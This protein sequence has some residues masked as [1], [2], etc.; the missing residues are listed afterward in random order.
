M[1]QWAYLDQFIFQP[2][3][4]SLGRNVVG[5]VS[6]NLNG[7]GW[8]RWRGVSRL[9]WAW[10]NFDVNAT[11]H[12]IGGFREIVHRPGVSEAFPNAVHE[13]WTN[14]TNF[15]DLQASYSLIFAPPV[16]QAPV[17]GYSKGG[18]EVV[19]SKDGKQVESTAAY[20]M[21]CWKTIINNSTITL[22]CN[23]VFGQDPP[24]QFG[25]FFANS[26][27]YPG[28][29]YDNIGRFWYLELKKKF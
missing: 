13:H 25:S 18:K 19:T 29:V 11:W 10:H 6:N 26:N 3:N 8:F 27:N 5:Q 16:E 15:I 20:S 14:P 28:F 1:S 24:K 23:D 2:T 12:Y 4:F 9:D 7:D 22:G 21:P 17:A